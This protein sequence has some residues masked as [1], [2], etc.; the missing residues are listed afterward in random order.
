M[1]DDVSSDEEDKSKSNVSS[2]DGDEAK[3]NDSSNEDDDTI[4]NVIKQVEMK[5]TE[6]KEDSQD[7]VSNSHVEESLR[8]L[9]ERMLGGE[10]VFPRTSPL[11]CDNWDALRWMSYSGIRR[12]QFSQLVFRVT[13]SEKVN[14]FWKTKEENYSERSLLIYEEPSIIVI[15][16]RAESIE[17]LMEILDLPS[18]EIGSDALHKYWVA[19]SVID[20]SMC[21]LGLSPMTSFSLPQNGSERMQSCFTLFTPLESIL[22]SV[23]KGPSYTDSGAFLETTAVEIAISKALRAAHEN[24][25]DSD[26]AWKHQLILGTLHAFV[27]SG[28]QQDLE[29]ALHL[30][31]RKYGGESQDNPLLPSEIVDRVDDNG[32]AALQLACLLGMSSAVRALTAVGANVSMKTEE[33]QSSLAHLCARNLDDNGLAI[34]LSVHTRKINPNSFTSFGRSP[35]YTA[36]M[37]GRKAGQFDS[38]ALR[39]CLSVLKSWGGELGLSEASEV[40]KSLAL[41]FRHDDLSVVLQFCPL[42]FPLPTDFSLSA[43]Y[44]YPLHHSIRC[45]QTT[46]AFLVS[47]SSVQTI[48]VLLKHGFELNER[49]DYLNSST[50]DFASEYVGYTPLQLL[51]SVGSDMERRKALC[52]SDEFLVRMKAIEEV[53]YLLIRHGGR[54]AVDNPFPTRSR[55]VDNAYNSGSDHIATPPKAYDLPNAY[56]LELFGGKAKVNAARDE[57]VSLPAVQATPLALISSDNKSMIPSTGQPGGS[58]EKSCAICW[59]PFGA[60]RNRQHRCR[61]SRRYLCDECSTKRLKDGSIEHRVSDGQFRLAQLDAVN[62]GQASPVS[63]EVNKTHVSPMSAPVVNRATR[64]ELENTR[65]RESLLGGLMEQANNFVFGE[66]DE[67]VTSGLGG[68]TSTLN[69]TRD[70]LNERGQKIDSLAEKSEKM[71]EASANFADMAK[72]LRKQSEGGFFW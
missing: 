31:Q 4:I 3:S 60:I 23:V 10:V 44:G 1:V 55:S 50:D 68:M 7:T 11:T 49:M 64:T 15:V 42:R 52:N 29:D 51:S 61:I 72:Q 25:N 33:D 71:V 59:K 12:L 16:R 38:D 14:L 43:F 17:E 13:Q 22:L 45:L 28:R 56:V 69:E 58:D 54:V 47:S 46:A 2:D 30:A 67:K 5:Q 6:E 36:I 70:A 57:F 48:D 62:A 20:L 37:E 18:A 21:K 8:D 24:R 35:M 63:A 39:R 66:G 9:E 32:L 26:K 40:V 34:V 65:N 41:S 19:E 53:A 27:V